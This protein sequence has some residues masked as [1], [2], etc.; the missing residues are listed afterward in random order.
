V[1]SAAVLGPTEGQRLA[2]DAA[3]RAASAAGVVIRELRE[4]G[5]LEAVVR[6][7]GAIWG[8]DTSPPVPLELLRALT[9]AGSYVAGAYDGDEL[10]GAA[11]G[12]FGPPSE[13]AMH[14]HIAGVSPQVPSRHVG[15]ALK[16][17]QRAWC[18]ERGLGEISW[19]FDPLVSRNAYFNLEKLGAE[20]VDYLPNFY[21]PMPDAINGDDDTDR[22]LVRWRL[23]DPVVAAACAGTRPPRSAAALMRQGSA[24]VALGRSQD[25]GPVSGTA[26][27]LAN[28]VAVPADIE[29]MRRRD[30]ALAVEWRIAVRE[31]LMA[32]LA[33]E[34]RITGF[35]RA[36]WYIVE[37]HTEGE[38]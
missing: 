29:A 24:R 11:V 10:A 26:D 34:G 19:T 20:A 8:R 25:D 30:P 16:V 15:F 18:L 32:L 1:T 33:G 13:Q 37:Q 23:A 27:V 28:L 6:L 5:E 36:G 17:H 4:L 3:A 22:L 21:G 14:S 31:T 38:G 35:D 2:D 9:K 7:Y 12:F